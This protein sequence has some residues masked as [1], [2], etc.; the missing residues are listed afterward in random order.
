MWGNI[1]ETQQN[2]WLAIMRATLSAEG[3][4]RVMAEWNADDALA[5]QQ[6][7]G[8]GQQLIFGKK[9]AEHGKE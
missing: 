5:A 6:G 4:N 7:S 1:S 8:G 9:T 3:Y 2:A